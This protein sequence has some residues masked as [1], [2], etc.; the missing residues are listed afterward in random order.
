MNAL[1]PALIEQEQ[2][3]VDENRSTFL[4]QSVVSNIG[5]YVESGKLPWED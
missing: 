2:M 4:L 1:N 3:A 5:R